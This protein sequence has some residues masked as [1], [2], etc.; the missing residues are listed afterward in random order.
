[1]HISV[2]L[3]KALFR[4]SFSSLFYTVTSDFEMED[5]E[6]KSSCTLL[7]NKYHPN[8]KFLI[9]RIRIIIRITVL[10]LTPAKIYLR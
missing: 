3:S 9:I 10:L 4:I 5:I 1:M 2:A 8:Y 7:N 6:M